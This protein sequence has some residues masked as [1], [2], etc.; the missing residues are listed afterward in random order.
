MA[1]NIRAIIKQPSKQ[2]H[3]SSMVLAASGVHQ[4]P[5]KFKQ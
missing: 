3:A 2:N 1:M 5:N 4:R